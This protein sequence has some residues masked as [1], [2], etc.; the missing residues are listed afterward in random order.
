[1]VCTKQVRDESSLTL[2][3][4]GR[5]S[6]VQLA[7]TYTSSMNW[8][9][10]ASQPTMREF[11]S[12]TWHDTAAGK[13]CTATGEVSWGSPSHEGEVCRAMVMEATELLAAAV[14]VYP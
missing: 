5:S 13:D 10:D 3:Y 4:P 12:S 1:M 11:A 7:D 2:G 9:V 8:L 6:P 14:Q